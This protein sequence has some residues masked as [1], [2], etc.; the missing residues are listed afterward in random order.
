MFAIVHVGNRQF[1]VQAGDSIC[2]LSIP[3][4]KPNTKI[5]LKTLGIGGDSGFVIEDSEL[6]K[7]VVTATVL[8]HGRG[9]KILVFKK[10]RRKGYR[11]T[12]GFRQAFTELLVSEIKLPDGTALAAKKTAKSKS[13]S[14]KSQKKAI[15][16][17]KTTKEQTIEKEQPSTAK[18][19]SNANPPKS[20]KADVL[21]PKEQSLSSDK[22]TTKK[23][24]STVSKKPTAK[25]KTP[26][27]SSKKS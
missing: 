15:A 2:V 24:K 7:V 9:K 18:L 17:K 23:V 6:K 8:R 19:A 25:K 21:K 11:R 26:V 10:K 1:Q 14:M 3:E 27:P 4:S 22:A 5:K 16:T 12:R 13:A 20:K